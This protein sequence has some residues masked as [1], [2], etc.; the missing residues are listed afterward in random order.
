M[1]RRLIR[2]RGL[3]EIIGFFVLLLILIAVLVP[4]GLYLLSSPAQQ[5][6]A[7]QSANGYKLTA[8][9]QLSEFAIAYAQGD[10]T[11][12]LPAVLPVYTNGNLYLVFPG[13]QNPEVPVTVKAYLVEYSTGSGSEWLTLNTNLPV[14]VSKSNSTFYNGYKAIEIPLSSIYNLNPNNIER[15]AIVTQLGNIIYAYPPT[16]IPLPKIPSLAVFINLQ[17]KSLTVVAN[18]QFQA[19]CPSSGSIALTQLVKEY[20]GTVTFSGSFANALLNAS[21]GTALKMDMAYIGPICFTTDSFSTPLNNPAATFKGIMNGTFDC[22]NMM[23]KGTIQGYF[24]SPGFISV[25]GASVNGITLNGGFINTSMKVTGLSGNLNFIP[26]SISFA[27]SNQPVL[28][29]EIIIKNA[30]AVSLNLVNVSVDGTFSGTFSGI[31]NGKKVTISGSNKQIDGTVEE[32]TLTG[33]IT[34]M[35]FT[36]RIVTVTNSFGFTQ[37][38]CYSPGGI[39]GT[40]S[41]AELETVVTNFNGT[42][43]GSASVKY[44]NAS[45]T[46]PTPGLFTDFGVNEDTYNVSF[47]SLSGEVILSGADGNIGEQSPITVTFPVQPNFLG[48]Y[49][50]TC[51]SIDEFDGVIDGTMNLDNGEYM[52][53]GS[54]FSNVIISIPQNAYNPD[55]NNGLVTGTGFNNG[56]YIVTPLVI[57]VSFELDNPS[58][59]TD[60]FTMMPIAVKELY[61][62]TF[63]GQNQQNQ[64]PITGYAEYIGTADVVL[65]PEI[66][67]PPFHNATYTYTVDIPVT[68][69]FFNVPN[70]QDIHNPQALNNGKVEYV[71]VN[72]GLV[73]PNG[74]EATTQIIVTPYNL[75][76]YPVS[77]SSSS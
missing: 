37:A 33:S 74:Y 3:S 66:V 52:Q 32:G 42:T 43:I 59:M 9:Q 47:N 30:Q 18:P 23:I 14:L 69:S 71:E 10:A 45:P 2:N 22:A 27:L 24:T 58:N 50:S 11:P 44:I 64:Q 48:Q 39:A 17:P 19:L 4:L 15:V 57:R 49:P 8:E 1:A 25:E 6:Q 5:E 65:N 28:P 7:K 26:Q 16:A 20:G 62:F 70:I 67:I 46:V 55:S 72:L 34:E 21:T 75:I 76:T 12:Q 63:L 35:T 73:T 51:D 40:I 53:L 38:I 54:L 60:E 13:G 56:F 36:Q 41:Q 61:Y 29:G 77:G 31:L 68:G